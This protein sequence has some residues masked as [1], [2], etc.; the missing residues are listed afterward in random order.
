[1]N[2]IIVDKDSNVNTIQ[3]AIDLID[4][5]QDNEIFIKNGTY[6]EK[7]KI[8]FY[9]SFSLRI[10]GESKENT[11]ISFNDFARKI[12]QDGLEYNTFR[13]S[14]LMLLGDNITLEN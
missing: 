1:M 10:I 13:T 14:S 5:N 7:L 2:K 11:I 3:K 4:I 9:S 12:H 8:K 6:F